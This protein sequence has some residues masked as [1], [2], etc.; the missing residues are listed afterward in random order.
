[1]ASPGRVNVATW[2]R[3]K[4][5]AAEAVTAGVGVNA[6]VVGSWDLLEENTIV[7]IV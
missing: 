3:L 5:L 4:N 2:Y 7:I 6:K 1:M